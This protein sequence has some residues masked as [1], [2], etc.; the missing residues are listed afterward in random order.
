M[1]PT[2]NHTPSARFNVA[3]FYADLVDRYQL[4]HGLQTALDCIESGTSWD[5]RLDNQSAA[6]IPW[7][8]DFCETPLLLTRLY[9]YY[10]EVA[11]E[12]QVDV[13]LYPH[14]YRDKMSTWAAAHPTPTRG[15]HHP[16]ADPLLEPPGTQP[17]WRLPWFAHTSFRE[18]LA[19][20]PP[21]LRTN[22]TF[23]PLPRRWPWPDFRAA[24][25]R[26]PTLQFNWPLFPRPPRTS[27]TEPDMIRVMR[28]FLRTYL[29]VPDPD[30]QASLRFLQ[31][32][33]I[34]LDSGPYEAPPFQRHNHPAWGLAFDLN[35]GPTRRQLVGLWT[36]VNIL[37]ASYKRDFETMIDTRFFPAYI[38]FSRNPPS[39]FA[40]HNTCTWLT[41]PKKDFFTTTD[42]LQEI[43]LPP[44][45]IRR[46]RHHLRR[47]P[48]PDEPP[49]SILLAPDTRSSPPT[50][51]SGVCTH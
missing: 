21:E 40:G 33:L 25:A 36:R 46:L 24:Q 44:L 37:P 34:L 23:F 42:Q 49:Y 29:D 35:K 18:W 6:P 20:H 14:V 1:N 8:F 11:S 19:R 30:I 32:L 45:N 31:L 28:R 2:P 12:P 26:L 3:A 13:F 5:T 22:P 50:V 41:G 47:H 17:P 38:S 16:V 15:W 10:P 27:P 39:P 48:P 9:N 43:R 51:H 4:T 7:E